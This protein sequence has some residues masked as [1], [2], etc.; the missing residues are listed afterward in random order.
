M[1]R[2]LV[3]CLV[4][5]ALVG[6]AMAQSSYRAGIQIER[7]T[8]L[9]EKRQV[10]VLL[11]P[12]AIESNGTRTRH[13]ERFIDDLQLSN[14]RVELN[15]HSSRI[16]PETGRS[17]DSNAEIALV[18]VVNLNE[19][20]ASK[21]ELLR[22]AK[23]L[24]A[25]FGE[26]V[27]NPRC[28]VVVVHQA[29]HWLVADSRDANFVKARI[30]SLKSWK[31]TTGIPA[32]INGGIQRGV[33][34]DW[35]TARS[36]HSI[37][38]VFSAGSAPTELV[39]PTQASAIVYFDFSTIEALAP[40]QKRASGA[41][42]VRQQS[43]VDG[44]V[45]SYAINHGSALDRYSSEALQSGLY[46]MASRYRLVI[47]TRRELDRDP[48]IVVRWTIPGLK[49]PLTAAWNTPSSSRAIWLSA[50]VF[51]LCAA[52][53]VLV[54]KRHTRR[55]NHRATPLV[56]AH[57]QFATPDGPPRADEST[58]QRTP[59]VLDGSEPLPTCRTR[60]VVQVGSGSDK[61]VFPIIGKTTVGRSN[62]NDIVVDDPVVSREHLELTFDRHGVWLRDVGSRNGTRVN[63]VDVTDPVLLK[64]QDTIR[65]G[66][67][68]LTMLKAGA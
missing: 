20:R 66:N 16:L 67:T 1:Y 59:I 53:L 54:S 61:R 57:P 65:V 3:T 2:L 38:A 25:H 33:G 51:V 40:G 43:K 39:S 6:Q 55:L 58:S 64:S 44:C 19:A 17:F 28:R 35:K 11:R 31:P 68:T 8:V 13:V 26:I 5:A 27:H 23:R 60:F 47:E 32:D 14:L 37:I 15:G 24:Y 36:I 41:N 34:T 50:L 4:G 56:W 62:A 12:Y 18:L 10:E 45:A 46:S 63:G 48:T 21:G 42:L 49:R 22:R 30:D 9:R 29:N 52:S 7:V